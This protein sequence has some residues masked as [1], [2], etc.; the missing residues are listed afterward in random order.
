MAQILI[1]P[2][3]LGFAAYS[4]H[5]LE[6]TL[7]D[8]PI[9]LSYNTNKWHHILENDRHNFNSR[10]GQH[11]V[12][13]VAQTVKTKVTVVESN[14]NIEEPEVEDSGKCVHGCTIMVRL[15]L[16]NKVWQ[17]GTAWHEGDCLTGG[18]NGGGFCQIN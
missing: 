16:V 2:I 17:I 12:E 10:C 11:C 18:S 4:I 7:H 5:K 8:L 14:E 13:I 3:F 6:E 9:N 1:N 15:K